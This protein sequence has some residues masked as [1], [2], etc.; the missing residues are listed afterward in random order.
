M[1][2]NKTPFLLDE[3]EKEEAVTLFQNLLRFDTTNPGGN[4]KPLI[5]FCA[6]LLEDTGIPST[7]LEAEPGRSNLIARLKGSG[8]GP[9]LLL[10]AHVDVVPAEPE[11]WRFPPFSGEIHEGWIYGRGAVDMKDFAAMALYVLR[12]IKRRNLNLKGDLVL[13]L[14]ADEEAGGSL[15]MKWLCEHHYD[16]L[17]A[18]Y[19]LTEVGG[20]PIYLRKNRI[21]FPIQV[22]EKGFLWLR[23]VAR[24]EPGHGSLPH[25]DQAVKKLLSALSCLTSSPLPFR[26]TPEVSR[27]LSELARELGPQGIVLQ[28]LKN[29]LLHPLLIRLIPD[30]DQR[31]VFSALLHNTVSVTVLLA[32]EKTNVIPAGAMAEL[33]GRYLPGVDTQT[34][35]S[36]IR[37]RTGEDIEL[38]PFAQGA[39]ASVP[40]PTPLSRTIEEVVAERIPNAQ[41]IPSVTSGF[42]DAKWLIE[43]GM[44]VYGFTP[45]LLPPGVSFSQLFH[46]HN[47]RAP[48]TGYL[49]GIETLGEIVL[50]FLG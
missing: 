4:E 33:D 2:G 6:R 47:E 32:G 36:E 5:E 31:L 29:P 21:V 43:K 20:F 10:S 23:A 19:G 16:L 38:I 25:E 22:A 30:R 24:G 35:L 12:E 9:S 50:R 46:G 40:Y 17:R 39:P 45:L 11:G 37:E 14:V 7:I 26:V 44:I 3:K 34:F 48:I 42:T 41:L 27:F 1:P 49:W 8:E 28:L 15:G 18:D 13:A